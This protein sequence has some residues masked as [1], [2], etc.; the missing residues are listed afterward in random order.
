[1]RAAERFGLRPENR[2]YQLSRLSATVF[3]ALFLTGI[4]EGAA[5][6][7]RRSPVIERH[8][9]GTNA[10]TVHVVLA[11]AAATA[12]I[13]IQARRSR[14]PAHLGQS[15]WA[16]PFSASSFARLRRTI[17]FGCGASP[18]NLARVMATVPLVLV[19][20]YAPFRMGAQIVGGLDP[21][22]TVNA[23]GGPTY[24]GALL[25]H[26]LDGVAGFYAAAFL[27]SQLLLPAAAEDR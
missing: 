8:V 18:R 10:I 17:L 11:I 12:V 3:L 26:W 23:W 1:M 4:A 27:L 2:R 16:A 6:Y 13:G 21:N 24:L 25:A 15:P 7:T 19:L 14:R 5:Q 20:L 9:A 22:A